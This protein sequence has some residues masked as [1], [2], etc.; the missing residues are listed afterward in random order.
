MVSR[1]YEEHQ[2][3]FNAKELGYS[4]A[5]DIRKNNVLEV[6]LFLQVPPGP[7]FMAVHASLAK[8]TI[9]KKSSM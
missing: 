1:M 9:W 4:E 6:P 2:K 8:C 3:C 5:T 7:D